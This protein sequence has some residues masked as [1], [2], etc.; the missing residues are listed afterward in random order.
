MIFYEHFSEKHVTLLQT[1]AKWWC[2]KLCIC[3]QIVLGQVR[4][5]YQIILL[6]VKQVKTAN[7][8]LW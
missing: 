7:T 3:A 5:I 1:V 4:E 8:D 6:C 2:I